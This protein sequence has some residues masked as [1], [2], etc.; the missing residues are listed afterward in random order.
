MSLTP[1]EYIDAATSPEDRRLRRAIMFP[2]LY[3]ASSGKLL[4]VIKAHGTNEEEAQKILA[5]FN[6]SFKEATNVRRLPRH[7]R[8]LR[9]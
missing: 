3:G 7:C 9:T 5:E 4:D 1:R 2:W 6:N 8:Y